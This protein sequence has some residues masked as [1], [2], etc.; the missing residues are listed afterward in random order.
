LI[1]KSL[2]K[3]S[4]SPVAAGCPGSAFTAPAGSPA[5]IVERLRKAELEGWCGLAAMIGV[6]AFVAAAMSIEVEIWDATCMPK[7]V[8]TFSAPIPTASGEIVERE[9]FVFCDVLPGEELERLA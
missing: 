7:I 4:L 2:A 8:S 6:P 5:N 1:R 9:G 3:R